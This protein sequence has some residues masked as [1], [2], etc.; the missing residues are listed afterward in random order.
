MLKI[1]Y[2]GSFAESWS[3]ET[4]IANALEHAGHSV[5][6]LEEAE[7]E[8]E[9]VVARC[10]EL[11][12]DV[13]L[14]A[15][16]RLMA[17]SAG[18]PT[19]EAGDWPHSGEAVVA[20]LDAARPHVGR[21]VT[22]VFDLLAP[23]FVLGQGRFEWAL[24]VAGACDVFATTD[25]ATA[26]SIPNSAVIRQGV[27]DDVDHSAAWQPHDYEG[28]V[29]FLGRA[30]GLR[31]ALAEAC[32]AQ[33]G[34][35]FRVVNDC[36]GAELTR[37]VR[38]YR[39]VVGPLWPYYADY[40]SNRLYVVTGH[41]GL[42]AAPSV[43]GME[44]EGWQAWRNYLPLPRDAASAVAKLREFVTRYHGGQLETIRRQGFEHAVARCGY[45]QRVT[46][47]LAAVREG[48][49]GEASDF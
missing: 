35:R 14:G 15:K 41:G 46:E 34:N 17:G 22:W 3:T 32:G 12:P 13:L 30:Y 43:A 5:E 24:R 21:T 26:P 8:S 7:A 36:R 4:Y 37:L 10:R 47:L 39:V 23:D 29:L 49:R 1:L 48:M 44:G 9:S 42:F 27:P 2:L 38:S 40:W 11:K 6:R 33:F 20:M 45:T 25:G 28:D 16:W 18:R 19:P 31:A